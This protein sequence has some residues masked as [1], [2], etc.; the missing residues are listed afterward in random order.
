[1]VNAPK[2][3]K[4]SSGGGSAPG[5]WTSHILFIVSLATLLMLVIAIVEENVLSEWRWHQRDYRQLQATSGDAR[6]REL[7]DDIRIELRQVDLPRLGTSD[8]C[9]TCHLGVDNPA[10]ADAAQPHRAHPGKILS[11]HPTAE[12]GC[13][14]CHRGQGEATNFKEAKAID[15]HWDYPL[16]PRELTESSCGVCHD[17]GGPLMAGH[18]PRLAS[19]RRLF[20][21]RGC[22]SCHKLGGIGGQLGPALDGEGR[23]TRHELPMGPVAGEHTLAN[24]LVQHFLD[25]QKVVAGSR[26]SPPKLTPGEIRDLTTYMLSLQGRDLPQHY[27]APDAVAAWYRRLHEPMLD[28]EILYSIYCMNCHGEGTFGRWD[29]FFQ[30]FMPAV[31]GPGLRAMADEGFLRSQIAQGRPGTIMPGWEQH[32]GGLSDGQF[33]ALLEYLM[34]RNEPQGIVPRAAPT[35]LAGGDAGRGQQLFD[36][37]CSACHGAA[38]IGGIAPMLANRVFL[39]N[40]ADM[41]IAETIVNGRADTAMPSFGGVDGAAGLTDTEIRDVL[42]YIRSLDSNT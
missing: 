7:A 28:G 31:R 8:R 4:G 14:I 2:I 17:P 33:D 39:Q 1:M 42:A 20:V 6:Q 26:M 40:A 9:V 37:N 11:D 29:P 13:T 12:F 25:P 3:R 27:I 10:M 35:N 19:G 15:V 38:G 18:A 41:L 22:P 5:R 16:L 32:A 23:K 30:S 21:D 34:G 24:W 36:Q